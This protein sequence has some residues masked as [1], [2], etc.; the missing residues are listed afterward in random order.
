MQS[1]TKV[2]AG[3]LEAEIKPLE[4]A[5]A[6]ASVTAETFLCAMKDTR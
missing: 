3:G 2:Q 4:L 5:S 6:G 1:E